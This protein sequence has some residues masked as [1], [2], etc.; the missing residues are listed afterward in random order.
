MANGDLLSHLKTNR[1]TLVLPNLAEDNEVFPFLPLPFPLPSHSL[2]PSSF[3]SSSLPKYS[4]S[5]P[6]SMSHDHTLCFPV[7]QISI[8][9]SRLLS[10]CLQIASGM[11]Y[12]AEVKI[13]HRDLAA[14]NCM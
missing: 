9:Q 1:E 6:P 10:I 3:L 4:E 7:H 14:R 13:V 11:Q 5:L 12:L 2:I 8:I